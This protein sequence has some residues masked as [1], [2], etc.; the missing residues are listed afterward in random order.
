MAVPQ[1]KLDEPQVETQATPQQPKVDDNYI[2]M[3]A[4]ELSE[5]LHQQRLAFIPPWPRSLS[6]SLPLERLQSS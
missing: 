6:A 4:K 2:L 5:S 1:L 3:H